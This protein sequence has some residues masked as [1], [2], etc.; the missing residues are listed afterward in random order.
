MTA[1]GIKR[2]LRTA[3]AAA[4]LAL[5]ISL[6]LA[7]WGGAESAAL[8]GELVRLHVLADSDEQY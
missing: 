8:S 7:V 3:C 6:S 5:G 4:L 1:Y 2:K